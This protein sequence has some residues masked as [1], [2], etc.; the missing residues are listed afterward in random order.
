MIAKHA[1]G[2]STTKRLSLFLIKS[3]KPGSSETVKAIDAAFDSLGPEM[4]RVLTYHLDNVQGFKIGEDYSLLHLSKGLT[5]I[6]GQA[7]AEMLLER[8][9]LEIDRMAELHYGRGS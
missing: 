1:S 4:K 7:A 6:F 2:Y 8:V 9:L 3:F 5:M